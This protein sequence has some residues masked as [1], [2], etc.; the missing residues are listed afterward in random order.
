MQQ[1][2]LMDFFFD[3]KSVA[4]VGASTQPG[5]I[6]Y[7]I[8]K[9]LIDSKFKGKIYPIHLRGERI[10]GVRSYKSISDLPE[11]V[12]LAVLAIPS[13]QA[14]QAVEEC[15][16]KGVKGI[17]IISGGFKELG[18][19]GAQY[20]S[21]VA[22]IASRYKMR[23]IGPNCVGIF[24]SRNRLDTFFQPHY[25]MM[26]P[27]QGNIALLTQSGTYGLTLLEWMAEEELGA[28]KFVSY[29]NKVD[30]GEI[31]MLRFLLKDEDTKVIGIY[32]EGLE[33]GASFMRIA[34]EVSRKKPIVIFKS[35]RTEVAA[36][37]ALSHTGALAGNIAVFRGAMKQCG[38]ISADNLE[39]MFD[40]LKILSLQP[41]PSGSKIAMVTNGA[42]PCISAVD[43][44]AGTDLQLA[45]LKSSTL[46]RL[47]KK[48][49]PFCVF[50]NPLDITGSAD[51][52]MYKTAFQAFLQDPN[53]S[54]IMPFFVFQDGPI[55][56]TQEQLYQFMPEL[57][58]RGKTIVCV[59]GGGKFTKE[60][61]RKFQATGLPVIPTPERA[62]KALDKIFWYKNWLQ[63]H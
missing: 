34:K 8:L 1:K 42:G 51:A 17:I 28:S 46:S 30:V 57:L 54:I 16:R 6:G 13:S 29:G 63:T 11:E 15:G 18:Q 4:L 47:K 59:A 61:V 60:Q 31:D 32:L 44:L 48:L 5:K 27:K 53:V 38:A 23:V 62:I 10:L 50:S 21:Q 33:D 40:I 22:A 14:P 45:N 25:A 3:A 52:S 39:E 20:E 56:S 9:S 41:L 43:S 37:A 55:A 24:N 49:P 35:G 2:D 12:E 58:G 7:E 26:R 19:E 36:K